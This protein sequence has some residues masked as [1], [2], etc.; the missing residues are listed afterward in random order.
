MAGSSFFG[1]TQL[2]GLAKVGDILIPGD[3][4][5][6]SFTASK[7]I[8]QVDRMLEYMSPSDR[9]GVQF[10]CTLF[11]FCP[12][13]AVRGI[14]WLSERQPPGPLGAACRMVN[15]GVKGVVMSLY[16]SDIGAGPSIYA[17][18]GY[19]AKVVEPQPE[20]SPTAAEAG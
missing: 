8:D 2:R 12:R 3:A 11:R 9:D 16:Y 5:F 18:I 1:K 6:P 17:L 4:E 7:S 19:D 20:E 14:M 15:I 13:F 10:L